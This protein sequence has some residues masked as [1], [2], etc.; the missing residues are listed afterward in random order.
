MRDS[1]Q[2]G[3]LAQMKRQPG[4]SAALAVLLLLALVSWGPVVFG[5]E[6]ESHP[7]TAAAPAG[8]PTGTT[9]PTSKPAAKTTK[10]AQA[11]K[12]ASGFQPIHSVAE[13]RKRLDLWRLPLGLE[14][15]APLTRELLQAKRNEALAAAAARAERTS[16]AMAARARA[17][18]GELEGDPWA[19]L[20]GAEAILE[21]AA[22]EVIDTSIE[23]ELNLT[24]TALLGAHRFAAFGN[25]LVQE[26]QQ[27]G[28]YRLKTV[29]PR[30]VELVYNDQLT[31]VRMPAP[32]ILL[33]S[34]PVRD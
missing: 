22:P 23:V 31:V 30:E 14:K 27:I 2:R 1:S 7:T 24:G 29:R 10:P 13:A 11:K 5:S 18:A 9:S 8:A 34:P 12:K 4:K 6:G 21:G 26:G 17:E 3:L 19:P 32:E 16:A 20:P 25:R 15:A 28:R 33:Q